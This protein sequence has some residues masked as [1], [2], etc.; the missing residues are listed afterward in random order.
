[1]VK[2][3]LAD[4]LPS[5]MPVLIISHPDPCHSTTNQIQYLVDSLVLWYKYTKKF[6]VMN[7]NAH[8]TLSS[9]LCDMD[10]NREVTHNRILIL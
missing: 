10:I 1:M 6:E 7:F 5:V 3:Q 8:I 4:G 9:L 2:Y